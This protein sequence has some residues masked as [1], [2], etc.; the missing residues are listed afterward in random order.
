M[1][2]FTFSSLRG[3]ALVLPARHE[4]RALLESNLSAA[5]GG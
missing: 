2:K 5:A 4:D 1:R 3:H